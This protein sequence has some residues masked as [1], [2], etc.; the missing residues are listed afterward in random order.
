MCLEKIEPAK[1]PYPTVRAGNLALHSLYNPL[2]EA[3]KFA[4][5]L[6]VPQNLR[7]CI[8]IECALGYIIPFLRKKMHG[9]KIVSLHVSDFYTSDAL[10]N[11]P[12]YIENK[13]FFDEAAADAVWS[14][15][16]GPLTA[17]LE[18]AI[19]DTEAAYI[20]IIEWRPSLAVYGE[21]YA[22]LLSDAAAF[23]QRIDANRRTTAG[24]GRRWFVNAIK[25]ISHIN[26]TVYLK[27]PLRTGCI[28]AGAGPSLDADLPALHKAAAGPAPPLVIAVAAALPSLLDCG[29]K[30]D[31]VITSD[32][33][34]WALFHLYQYVRACKTGGGGGTARQGGAAHSP[35]PLGFC[36]N[37]ALPAPVFDGPTFA[38]AVHNYESALLEAAGVPHIR[39][40]ARG[41]VSA[42]AV[43]VALR[44]TDGAVWTIGIDLAAADI[45]THARSYY[46]NGFPPEQ[47]CRLRPAYSR[48]FEKAHNTKR[49]GSLN[50]YAAW[51]K[52]FRA[53]HHGR[54]FYFAA[55]PH[56]QK[57]DI[58]KNNTYSDGPQWLEWTA[59]KKIPRH[60][61]LQMLCT[62]LHG[63]DSRPLCQEISGLLFSDG[64]EHSIEEIERM[65]VSLALQNGTEPYG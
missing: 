53:A 42:T 6:A 20:K 16:R 44:I 9:A 28:V 8:L 52:E 7:C 27:A 10:Y 60:V 54:L 31:I 38:I 34:N 49:G 19:D 11:S 59:Q 21:K 55:Y 32:G 65:A 48:Q 25:N 17:F 1:S 24:F 63:K 40:A 46:F 51:F 47:D 13:Q 5:S 45:A 12:I 64:Q 61:L 62:A 37:A 26:K 39:L 58:S 4:A 23:I 15:S 29:V 57:N 22:A 50:V 56:T 30:P 3:E 41:T 2:S 35:P 18:T 14:P 43:D 36:V 33:G